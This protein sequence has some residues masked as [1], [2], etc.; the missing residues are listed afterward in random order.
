MFT[1]RPEEPTEWAG[2]PSEPLGPRPAAE[3]LDEQVVS[4]ATVGFPGDA[5]TSVSIDLTPSDDAVATNGA[6]DAEPDSA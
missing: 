6:S 5:V 1:T 4:A 2:L 3:S